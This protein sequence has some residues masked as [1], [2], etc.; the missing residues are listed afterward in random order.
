M[1]NHVHL[2]IKESTTPISIFLQKIE[3]SF[4]YWYNLKYKRTGHLFQG[5]FMSEPVENESYFLSVVR[6]IHLNPVKAGICKTPDEYPYSSY[7]YYFRS[8]R[9]SDGDLIFGMIE[10]E[11]FDQFHLEKADDICLDIEENKTFRKT[12]EEI[13]QLVRNVYGLENISQIQ[14][15]TIKQ[16]TPIIEMMIKSGASLRQ[17][18]RLTGISI[19]IINEIK[20]SKNTMK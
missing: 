19:T 12:D 7:A 5:R 1:S 15:L 9:Y 4:V 13:C 20:R 8:N 11:K 16:R 3:V 6:Y 17:I 18:S 10:K 14:N 2:L